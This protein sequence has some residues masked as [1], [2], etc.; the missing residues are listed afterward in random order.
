MENSN[1]RILNEITAWNDKLNNLK[2]VFGKHVADYRYIIRAK[3]EHYKEIKALYKIPANQ[4]EKIAS[5][6][7]QAE[8]RR[9]EKIAFPN[10]L[11]RFVRKTIENA[12]VIFEKILRNGRSNKQVEMDNEIGNRQK[13]VDIISSEKSLNKT[14]IQY[15]RKLK[16]V[17]DD[18]L[19]PKLR[20]GNTKGLKM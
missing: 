3:L 20:N 6:V 10:R 13:P 11:E 15:T 16:A 17:K 14:N 2:G 5:K 8:I 19:L 18:T 4:D 12:G 1:N 9:L 7:L